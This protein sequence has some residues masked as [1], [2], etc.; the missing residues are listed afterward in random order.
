LSAEARQLDGFTFGTL[1]LLL[2]TT[3]SA[4]ANAPPD[5]TEP[6]ISLRSRLGTEAAAP[7]LKSESTELRLRAFEKLGTAGTSTALELLSEALEAGGAA[8]TASERLAAV[9]ALAPHARDARARSAL[10]RAMGGA[11]TRDEPLEVIVRQS[12]A[13]ALARAGDGEALLALAQALRQPGRVSEA[14]RVAVR[15]HPPKS[16]EPLLSARGVPTPALAGLLG[17]LRYLRGRELLRTLAQT[18]APAL[19]SEALLALSKVDRESAVSL[20]KRFSKSEEHKSL[21]LTAARVLAIARDGDAAA[22]VGALLADPALAGDALGIALESP[23]PALTPVLARAKLDDPGDDERLLAALGRAG[24]KAALSHLERALADPARGWAA[25]Y[26]L[27]T[28]RDDAADEVLARALGRAATRADAARAAV[29]RQRE[30]GSG[31]SG[32]DDALSSLERSGRAA[33]RAAAAFC[34]ASLDAEA[35]ARLVAHRDS[36]LVRAAARAALDPEVALAAAE[37]LARE[38]DP[39]LRTALSLALVHR[40][41][42]DRVPTRVLAELFELRGAAAHLA[43]FALAAR[44]GIVERPRLRELLS[45]GDPLLRAHVALG[46]VRSNDSSSV[47][48]LDQAYRFESDPGVRLAIVTTLA[49]R[50]EPGRLRTLRLASDLDADDATR[51]AARRA[52]GERAARAAGE[53]D[54][55]AWIR[56]DPVPGSDVAAVVLGPAGLALPVY[57]DPDGSVTLAGLHDGFT[58]VTLASAAPGGDSSRHPPK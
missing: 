49:A 47:G 54:G 6:R 5:R 30:R 36:S 18:G 52:L 33:D 19:R 20:A 35:G 51:T 16:L 15:A 12:S 3:A 39:E 43:A 40:E 14:A 58:R 32:L 57:P 24:G 26:A 44:D 10:V 45:S 8:R 48:L 41:A 37:R 13:L 42:A 11:Q 38:S 55:T 4:Q 50:A 25:A 46:L 34:R 31:V 56:I 22:A 2:A 23:S 7:L 27:A 29:L 9:R 28:S 1:L 21:R 17:D 53:A